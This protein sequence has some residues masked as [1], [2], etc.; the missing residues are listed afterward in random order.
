MYSDDGNNISTRR[1]DGQKMGLQYCI[2]LVVRTVNACIDEDRQLRNKKHNSNRKIKSKNLFSVVCKRA[3]VRC[4]SN[5]IVEIKLSWLAI[6][7]YFLM[8][9]CCALDL[10]LF[11]IYNRAWHGNVWCG[12]DF[13]LL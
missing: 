2:V 11:F 10:S 4:F 13:Q 9:C 3:H 7:Y 12:A 5:L 6:R 8:F 1:I